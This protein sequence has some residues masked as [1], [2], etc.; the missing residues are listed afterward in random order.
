MLSKDLLKI[1]IYGFIIGDIIGV[2]Y[3]FKERPLNLKNPTF[4]GLWSDDSSMVLATM[5]S[6][7]ECKGI[8]IKDLKQKFLNWLNDGKYTKDNRTFGV[9][10]TTKTALLTGISQNK[11]TDNGNGALM[12]VLPLAFLDVDDSEILKVCGITHSHFISNEACLI[13]IHVL[14]KL[15]NEKLENIL[16]EMTFTKDFSQLKKLKDLKEEDIN[17]TA[18][19]VDT[20]ISTFWC[21]I[22]S[23]SYETALLKALNLGGDTDTICALVGGSAALIY[24]IDNIPKKWLNKII[25]NDLIEK[26]FF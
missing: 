10:N 25:D 22:H 4:L 19:V 2:P 17:S 3:E 7:R 18:Y 20:L 6:I 1:A 11:I 5:D 13:Y 14:R 16:K 8:N 26:C 23:N 24:G 21:L 12:R 15:P 9:G